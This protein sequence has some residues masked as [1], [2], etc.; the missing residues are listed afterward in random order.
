MDAPLALNLIL[1]IIA[2]FTLLGS[3]AAFVFK[4]GEL[5]ATFA[6]EILRLENLIDKSII[7]EQ[8]TNQSLKYKIETLNATSK[9]E[10]SQLESVFQDFSNIE[11]NKINNLQK[12]V[13]QIENFLTKTTEFQKRDTH[14]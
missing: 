6:K 3:V 13:S 7:T 1:A 4:A 14:Y 5:K 11:T 8:A 2:L 10:L 12:K 9:A